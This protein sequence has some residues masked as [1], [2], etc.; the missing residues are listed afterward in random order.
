MKINW[1]EKKNTPRNQNTINH[2]AEDCGWDM[3]IDACKAA[4]TKANPKKYDE[5]VKFLEYKLMSAHIN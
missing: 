5:Y 4:Y 3:A 2:F 1:P